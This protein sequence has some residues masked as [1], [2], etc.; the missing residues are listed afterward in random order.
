M[1]RS[2]LFL[3]LVLI[4]ILTF[5]SCKQQNS[6]KE[7]VEKGFAKPMIEGNAE[8]T[9]QNK[10]DED[11]L[12][13]PSEEE[14]EIEFSI[15][16]K[17]SQELKSVIEIP[18]EKR[19]LFNKEPSIKELTPSKMVISFIFKKEAEPSGGN[20][21]VGENVPINIKLYEASTGRIV[22]SRSV[23]ATCNTP[24]PQ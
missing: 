20:A 9:P 2:I 5:A 12:Y 15:K 16:N 10:G 7:Y 21:F 11:R 13:V 17:F 8:I 3:N 14:I 6:L 19:A 1:K 4:F 23:N 18:Q 22:S 24:P